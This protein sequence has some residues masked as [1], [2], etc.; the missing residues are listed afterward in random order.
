M[1]MEMQEKKWRMQL[2][3]VTN[4][5][6]GLS[7]NVRELHDPSKVIK[8]FV[9]AKK[10]DLICYQE[11]KVSSM[12]VGLLRNLGVDWKLEWASL[13][14]RGLIRNKKDFFDVGF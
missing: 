2:K 7:W 6:C 11:N 3:E 1:M 10:W 12:T 14:A 8:S 13:D 5:K 9:W 4:E